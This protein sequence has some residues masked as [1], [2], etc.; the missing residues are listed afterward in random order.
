MF[1]SHAYNGGGTER[2]MEAVSEDTSTFDAS[3]LEAGSAELEND[4]F[5][6]RIACDVFARSLKSQFELFN[7]ELN[8]LREL[9][10]MYLPP[11][12]VGQG[13]S[14]ERMMASENS[15]RKTI[16]EGT[17]MA[18]KQ[19]VTPVDGVVT[20]AGIRVM[21]PV[22]EA[23]EVV[24]NSLSY[25]SVP[26][27]LTGISAEV[28]TFNCYRIKTVEEGL[29]GTGQHAIYPVDKRT[30]L[31]LQD[32]SQVLQARWRPHDL[33]K[34]SFWHGVPTCA[35]NHIDGHWTGAFHFVCKVPKYCT[36][37]REIDIHAVYNPIR[38]ATST[39]GT[40][41]LLAR[42]LSFN[43]GSLP[44]TWFNPEE[45]YLGMG[46][47]CNDVL[48]CIEVGLQ[49]I[50]VGSV[51]RVKVLGVLA[52]SSQRDGR[53]EDEV[54]IESN[55]SG[56]ETSEVDGDGGG[57]RSG[58][59]SLESGF[60][61]VVI[62]E[63]DR[64][65][66]ELET[67]QDL[68][69]LRSGTLERIRLWF[70]DESSHA[71]S[72]DIE[73]TGVTSL[74]SQK[75]TSIAL[76]SK[77]VSSSDG[78]APSVK[79]P[80][81]AN[82]ESKT[83]SKGA[84]V[85]GEDS[86]SAARKVDTVAAAVEAAAVA[87][88][89]P[90]PLFGRLYEEFQA[91]GLTMQGQLRHRLRVDNLGSAVETL[92][93]DRTAALLKQRN[94]KGRTK[95]PAT[96][97]Q[98]VFDLSELQQFLP[99]D[100]LEASLAYDFWGGLMDLQVA[101]EAAE[102]QGAQELTQDQAL[103]SS[104]ANRLAIAAARPGSRFEVAS[105]SSPVAATS[106]DVQDFRVQL[107][108]EKLPNKNQ[109]SEEQLLSS[110]C[111]YGKAVAAA[112]VQQAHI[113]WRAA[114]HA[115]YPQHPMCTEGRASLLEAQA[116]LC[117]EAG[118]NWVRAM[119]PMEAPS[120]TLDGLGS[121]TTGA[122]GFIHSFGNNHESAEE[123]QGALGADAAAQYDSLRAA[124]PDHEVWQLWMTPSEL[125]DSNTVKN[126]TVNIDA[127][128]NREKNRLIAEEGVLEDGR[129]QQGMDSINQADSFDW[130]SRSFES[131]GGR[132]EAFR[133]RASSL[134]SSGE[135]PE[136]AVAVGAMPVLLNETVG[137]LDDDSYCIYATAVES[138]YS[139]D[140]DLSLSFDE[141]V[142][143]GRRGSN[144]VN[145]TSRISFWHDIPLTIKEMGDSFGS[146]GQASGSSLYSIEGR[147]ENKSAAS[148]LENYA[149]GRNLVAALAATSG[150]AVADAEA[151]DLLVQEPPRSRPD[152]WGPTGSLC[153]ICEC[154]LNTRYRLQIATRTLNNPLNLNEH[155]GGNRT[156]ARSLSFN[157]GALPRTWQ[158][159]SYSHP[160]L[161]GASGKRFTMGCDRPVAAI[162][163]G[164]RAVP[165]GETRPVKVLGALPILNDPSQSNAGNG[166]KA[167]LEWI[168]IVIDNTDLWAREVER[169]E[170]LD[171]LAPG[172]I[173]SIHGLVRDYHAAR[174]AST[175]LAK[176]SPC[177]IGPLV[178]VEFAIGIVRTAFYCYK[179]VLQRNRVPEAESVE[180]SDGESASSISGRDS[181]LSSARSIKIPEEWTS[182]F[183][184]SLEADEFAMLRLSGGLGLDEIF[185]TSMHPEVQKLEA[186]M[187]D[188]A[189]RMM[190]RDAARAY[191]EQRDIK[192]AQIE[193]FTNSAKVLA[194][195][196]ADALAR[197]LSVED[198][199]REREE[200]ELDRFET[201][202][203]KIE[204]QAYDSGEEALDQ[205]TMQAAEA[206]KRTQKA[207]ETGATC[208]FKAPMAFEELRHISDLSNVI[209][210]DCRPARNLVS[211]AQEHS[212]AD[213][214][215]KKVSVF[216]E[217]QAE[218]ESLRAAREAKLKRDS[219]EEQDKIK[220]SKL[221]SSVTEGAH[222]EASAM[223]ERPLAEK[224]ALEKA[225]KQAALRSGAVPIWVDVPGFWSVTRFVEVRSKSPI[226][227]QNKRIV[228]LDC[229][230]R[231]ASSFMANQARYHP[232][233]A[234]RTQ[235][236]VL[237]EPIA[238]WF[239]D[240]HGRYIKWIREQ[241]EF[242]TVVA[243]WFHRARAQQRAD[244]KR[245][246]LRV[247]I[248]AATEATVADMV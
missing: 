22:L 182:A 80:T 156:F 247:V 200:A 58:G 52:L 128:A 86:N 159:P 35:S 201:W 113:G 10:D 55:S 102:K 70:L 120:G 248:E 150:G 216:Y 21:P 90:T 205:A 4:V 225:S 72:K 79:A 224:L 165:A 220:L 101:G 100:V 242:A 215:M 9:R 214:A 54:A 20:E 237:T 89:K 162:E 38:H 178:G 88:M 219:I 87:S 223:T 50:H 122:S 104:L 13:G 56:N 232:R 142:A 15:K 118:A 111:F 157:I 180:Q 6:T 170:D 245:A 169:V 91:Y 37:L 144:L 152:L 75:R 81:Q 221:K 8:E 66:S 32:E 135:V 137:S 177:S 59:A 130:K 202:V 164:A 97:S 161:A 228:A 179:R 94:S 99:E 14:A 230:G 19:L 60:K 212:L 64:W 76:V 175:D 235:M 30:E 236:L 83:D 138:A 176:A 246:K 151:A 117:A 226:Q 106:Q 109:T 174:H 2:Y 229:D 92:L 103:E 96:P 191:Q 16:V 154:P 158:D 146:A 27:R 47:G 140:G 63:T 31:S 141:G 49:V 217:A 48:D 24:S 40:P 29:R 227:L 7:Q 112:V 190:K 153:W 51:R 148:V 209:F 186:L 168:L 207:M 239:M 192:W 115:Q 147:F 129:T 73:S 240:P 127:F 133:R 193:A 110:N 234:R 211:L 208:L 171:A 243:L 131:L 167:I 74:S 57:S 18:T 69:A 105:S 1:Q 172:T 198:S 12:A 206:Y 33:S 210:V 139:R 187:Q 42:P 3:S 125:L 78:A 195:V 244:E 53:T 184:V 194:S 189:E 231:Y 84:R 45:N 185:C 41:K 44:R 119:P 126:D 143:G 132:P 203:E 222:I 114:L 93:A 204:E 163:V 34:F 61:L 11:A 173:D 23:H 62:D 233:L 17:S 183:T 149:V 199:A 95:K 218:A 68:E 134:W 123:L 82:D 241:P 25:N 39:D 77:G 26:R 145:N 181:M 46:K 43:Y 188:D 124:S 155:N 136:W 98:A 67:V 213:E 238:K 166:G 196:N 65:A 28:E 160:A 71:G 107:R 197:G 36:E 85:A 121:T 5:E 116:D 108:A